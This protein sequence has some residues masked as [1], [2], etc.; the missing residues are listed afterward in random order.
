MEIGS[1]ERLLE[2]VG[3]A[4]F[5]D[6][7]FRKR[8]KE[9]Q[10]SITPIPASIHSV[11]L[12][13]ETLP[14]F[15]SFSKL[16][17]E[18]R[19]KIWNASIE[20]R[21]IF[22]LPR[23]RTT[24]PTILQVCKESRAEGLVQY[25]VL[26]YPSASEVPGV[27]GRN[28]IDSWTRIFFNKSIDTIFYGESPQG[29]RDYD[30]N[31]PWHELPTTALQIHHLA[32]SEQAWYKLFSPDG[33]F[34]GLKDRLEEALRYQ[35]LKTITIVL[36]GYWEAIEIHPQPEVLSGANVKLIPNPSGPVSVNNVPWT[37]DIHELNDQTKA[38]DLK[39]GKLE[40]YALSKADS[41]RIS[42]GKY[43][44]YSTDLLLGS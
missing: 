21:I 3:F 19:I 10:P 18:L 2:M 7:V 29:S 25:R 42:A 27:E 31:L 38:T 43:Q 41:D 23:I 9:R 34:E 16:P 15:P 33:A 6:L 26:T 17:A 5:K 35:P 8:T 20:P 28:N 32:L 11:T 24:V 13:A 36:D 14:A 37:P 39:I 44:R 1:C 22:M 30:W 4:T 40:R 12:P